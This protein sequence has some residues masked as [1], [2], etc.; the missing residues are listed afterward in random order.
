MPGHCVVCNY[1]KWFDVPTEG[2]TWDQ[3]VQSI[4]GDNNMTIRHEDSIP[5]HTYRLLERALPHGALYTPPG[6]LHRML[7]L[8]TD[9]AQNPHEIIR[10]NFTYFYLLLLMF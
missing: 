8:H 5:M 10:I 7:G 4:V 9:S 1:G 2:D 6:I 3:A